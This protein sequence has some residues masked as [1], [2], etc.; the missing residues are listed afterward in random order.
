MADQE[1]N[2][3]SVADDYTEYV[4]PGKAEQMEKVKAFIA[5]KKFIPSEVL[6]Q[7]ITWFYE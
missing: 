5:E 4:F 2:E 1:V 7:E 3:Q 6:D